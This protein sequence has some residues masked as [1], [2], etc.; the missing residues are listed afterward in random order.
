[1][2]VERAG[3]SDGN[4]FRQTSFIPATSVWRVRNTVQLSILVIVAPVA[5]ICLC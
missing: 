2:T 4:V 1:M 5:D 3:G